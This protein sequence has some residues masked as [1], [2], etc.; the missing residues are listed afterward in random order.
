M[1]ETFFPSQVAV[2]PVSPLVSW[3]RLSTRPRS[4]DFD[5][6]L[7]SRISDPL[8]FLSRQWQWGEFK[9]ENTGTAVT[10]KTHFIS[11]KVTQL[12][13]AKGQVMAMDRTRPLEEQVES[14]PV[15]KLNLKER[16][17]SGQRFKTMLRQQFPQDTFNDYFL[18]LRDRFMLYDPQEQSEIDLLSPDFTTDAKIRSSQRQMATIKTFKNKSID[19]QKLYEQVNTG[20]SASTGITLVNSEDGPALDQLGESFKTWMQDTFGLSDPLP[21]WEQKSLEYK[22]ACRVPQKADGIGQ[23]RPEVLQAEEFASGRLDWDAF[24]VTDQSSAI[25]HPDLF[26][27]PIT[28]EEKT[29][30]FEE[31]Y[32]THPAGI[33]FPGMPADRWWE[34]E[35]AK[36]NLSN[37]KPDTTDFVSMMLNEFQLTY[38][39]EWNIVPHTVPVGSLVESKYTIVTDSFG[40]KILIRPIADATDENWDSWGL[41]QLSNS[42]D[43]ITTVDNRIFIPPIVSHKATETEPLEKVRFIRDE[44]ANLVWAIESKIPHYWNGSIDAKEFNAEYNKYLEELSKTIGGLP[45]PLDK[46]VEGVELEYIYKVMNNEVPDNWIPFLPIKTDEDNLRKLQ[47]QRGAMP[48]ILPGRNTAGNFPKIRGNTTLLQEGL[49]PTNEQ[50]QVSAMYV[51]E[52]EVTRAGMEISGAWQRARW[53]NGKVCNWYSRKKTTGR[54]EGNSGLAFDVMERA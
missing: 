43:N 14:I 40:K 1:P 18:Q 20:N 10:A 46:N 49:D 6:S 16:I 24:N 2:Q 44:M 31:R 7:K 51:N 25:S 21:C 52:E 45:A 48:R 29:A 28:E 17:R 41:F 27:N 32:V 42:G 39:N 35:D 47:L 50:N 3:N 36:V 12:A 34:F 38:S 22:F 19:G 9:G 23:F 4:K 54:G 30:V 15:T 37:I 33:S 13:N 8:W 5:E 53:F 26:E 11:S